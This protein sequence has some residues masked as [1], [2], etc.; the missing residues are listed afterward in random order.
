VIFA[1]VDEFVGGIFLVK[2][3]T[4]ADLAKGDALASGW[5]IP[6]SQKL[7]FPLIIQRHG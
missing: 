3:K 4:V 1:L 6:G 2:P 7:S 5:Q